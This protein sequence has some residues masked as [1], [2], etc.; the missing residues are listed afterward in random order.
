MGESPSTGLRR[1]LKGTYSY[2][3]FLHKI[4]FKTQYN[5]Q[6]K[7][8]FICFIALTICIEKKN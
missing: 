2:G 4:K 6:F 5:Q 1:K 3:K 7:A 8:K